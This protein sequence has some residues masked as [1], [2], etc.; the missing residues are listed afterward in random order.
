MKYCKTSGNQS[1]ESENILMLGGKGGR[2]GGGGGG[3]QG[4][5]TWRMNCI[6]I[7]V[8]KTDKKIL[9]MQQPHACCVP[10]NKHRYQGTVASTIW[11]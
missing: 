5:N 4:G 10:F 2:G 3:G 9:I 8:A 1:T 6:I 7:Q 11:P